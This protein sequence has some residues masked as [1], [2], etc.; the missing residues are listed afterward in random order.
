MQAIDLE[1]VFSALLIFGLRLTDM[2]LDTIR[3]LFVMRGRK[4]LA[5]LIGGTQAAVF[6]VAV[7]AVLTR[8]LNP[9]TVIGYAAGFGAGV[10]VGMLA[11]ERLALGHAIIRVYSPE[12]GR[13]IAQALRQSGYAVTEFIARGK[14]GFITVVNCV[15][16][17]KDIHAVHAIVDTV[18]SK[19]FITMDQVN[20]LERGYFR[21]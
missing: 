5:G 6:I 1:P 14:A 12:S 16:A 4:L 10:I 20:T 17:R 9:W 13:Q 8:P 2:S 21:R 11:E 15:V 3:L 19:A 7:S 18:D